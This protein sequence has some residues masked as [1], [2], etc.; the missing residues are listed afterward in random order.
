MQ[1]IPNSSVLPQDKEIMERIMISRIPGNLTQ[2]SN[3][4]KIIDQL[5]AEV[6]NDYHFSLRKAIGK[7][8]YVENVDTTTIVCL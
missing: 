8:F 5:K 1:G 2:N 4:I 3:I 6:D 7:P